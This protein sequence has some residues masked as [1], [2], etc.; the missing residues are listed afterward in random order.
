MQ[1]NIPELLLLIWFRGVYHEVVAEKSR[2][3]EQTI[4]EILKTVDHNLVVKYKY[5]MKRFSNFVT[6]SQQDLFSNCV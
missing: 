2:Y 5:I 6:F 3:Y 4:L 1:I